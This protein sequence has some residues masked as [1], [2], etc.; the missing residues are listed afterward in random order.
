M[1]VQVFGQNLQLSVQLREFENYA[2][3]L[4]PSVHTGKR[5]YMTEILVSQSCLKEIECY[6][7]DNVK[8]YVTFDE[9]PTLKQGKAEY[10]AQNCRHL[11]S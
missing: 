10:F 2:G 7:D 3:N 9:R 1:R 11:R 8:E 5:L 4:P 6:V